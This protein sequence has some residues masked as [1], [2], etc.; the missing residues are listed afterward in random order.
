MQPITELTLCLSALKLA[1]CIF[2]RN[3]AD[4]AVFET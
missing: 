2:A 3:I 4:D 1:K